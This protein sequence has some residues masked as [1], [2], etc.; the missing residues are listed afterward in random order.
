MQL[1]AHRMFVGIQDAVIYTD[2][3]GTAASSQRVLLT[4]NT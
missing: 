3:A 2:V 1:T 4:L